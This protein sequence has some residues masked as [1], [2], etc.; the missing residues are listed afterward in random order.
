ENRGIGTTSNLLEGRTHNRTSS[1]RRF[2]LVG[3]GAFFSRPDNLFFRSLWRC[4][5]KRLCFTPSHSLVSMVHAAPGGHMPAAKSQA[6]ASGVYKVGY[7]SWTRGTACALKLDKRPSRRP[8]SRASDRRAPVA[9]RCGSDLLGKPNVRPDHG[10]R[11][12][13]D[14]TIE[15]MGSVRL[16]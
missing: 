6:A 4:Q 5:D 3:Q 1:K 7:C 10:R 2:P 8:L 16:A 14:F 12:R 15:L 11:L 9:L 13:A